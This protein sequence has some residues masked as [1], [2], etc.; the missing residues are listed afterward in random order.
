V[1]SLENF[2]PVTSVVISPDS[3]IAATHSK[4]AIT[5]WY[6]AI[7]EEILRFNLS[8][9]ETDKQIEILTEHYVEVKF[10]SSGQLVASWDDRGI[11]V[12]NVEDGCELCL[13]GRGS[14]QTIHRRNRQP[15][16]QEEPI[17][18]I[19]FSSN[20]QFLAAGY[21][22]GLIQVWDLTKDKLLLQLSGHYGEVWSVAFSPN[23]KILAAACEGGPVKCWTLEDGKERHAFHAHRQVCY[24]AFLDDQRL[25][26][27]ADQTVETWDINPIKVGPLN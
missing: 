4:T 7:G 16:M 2:E 1:Q 12:W 13:L 18:S 6:V 3:E 20:D 9:S 25:E 26:S 5:L 8:P 15:Y 24:V 27:R 17:I 10:S 22:H 21:E 11:S 14:D 19:A 23:G